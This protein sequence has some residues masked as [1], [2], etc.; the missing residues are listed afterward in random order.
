MQRYALWLLRINAAPLT[1]PARFLTGS[2]T[3]SS[4]QTWQV[5]Q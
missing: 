4:T 5:C 1:K 2:R 3:G